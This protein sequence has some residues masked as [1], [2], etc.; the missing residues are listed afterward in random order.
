[1]ATLV[2]V[3]PQVCYYFGESGREHLGSLCREKRAPVLVPLLV[4]L[5]IAGYT[6]VGTLPLVTGQQNFKILS[7][8][9]DDSLAELEKSITHL[10][11]SLD[12][13]PEV[14]LQNQRGLDLLFLEQGG[15]CMA[16]GETC[17]FYAN[18]SGV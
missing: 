15:L 7:R 18:H 6:A 9:V 10:E 11:F 16:L 1:M 3:I 12:S 2:Y 13:L 5:G 14:A 17:C 4:G 8:Q